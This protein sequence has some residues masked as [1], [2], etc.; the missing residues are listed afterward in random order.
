MTL[1]S[2]V[3]KNLHKTISTLEYVIWGNL[4]MY[5]PGHTG[6]HLIQE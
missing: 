3:T 1:F 5:F 4:N 2:S 6:S